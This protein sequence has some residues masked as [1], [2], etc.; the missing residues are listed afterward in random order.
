MV[1]HALHSPTYH[2]FEASE[3]TIS[4]DTNVVPITTRKIARA[5]KPL[6]WIKDYVAPKKTSLYSLTDHRCY[7]HLSLSYQSYIGALSAIIDPQSFKEAS[8]D[9]RY[10]SAMQ[11]KIKALE[12]NN[13]WCIF[14]LPPGMKAIGSKWVYKIKYNS[15]GEV[16]KFKARLVAKG[17][18]Q[19][20]GLDYHET[21]SPVAKMV[22]IRTIIFVAASNG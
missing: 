10:I 21:F 12:K 9:S 1:E 20:E 19:R 13:T 2:V 22:T 7:D 6:I 5:S 11:D 14:N 16:D 17:Y 15:T 8:Q 3:D 4:G 18:T